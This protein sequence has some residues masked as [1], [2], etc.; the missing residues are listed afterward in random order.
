MVDMIEARSGA[1]G[2]RRGE[3]VG[4]EIDGVYGDSQPVLL[5]EF[6]IGV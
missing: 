6:D 5:Y 3:V 2:R 4:V 1:V